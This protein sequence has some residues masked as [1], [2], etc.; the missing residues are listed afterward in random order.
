MLKVENFVESTLAVAIDADPGRTTVEVASGD[1]SKFP[2]D[3]DYEISVGN[4]EI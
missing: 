4:K 2:D 3:G 1:G